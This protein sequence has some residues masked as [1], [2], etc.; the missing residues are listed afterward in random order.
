M[1]THFIQKGKHYI[2]VSHKE[3]KNSLPNDRTNLQHYFE[4]YTEVVCT[5]VYPTGHRFNLYGRL[6]GVFM[7]PDGFDQELC[8]N[9]VIALP[10]KE[11]K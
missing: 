1:S 7:G 11:T 8:V 2:V 5:D 10:I 4:Q 9:D 3:A 6:V